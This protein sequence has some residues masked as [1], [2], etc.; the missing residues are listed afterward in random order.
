[1]L[2]LKAP[3]D[4]KNT[5][6]LHELFVGSFGTNKARR[7]IPN[8][9]YIYG[10]FECSYPIIDEETG[11]VISLCGNPNGPKV[12]YVAYEA[13][14]NATTMTDAIKTI[15]TGEFL[16]LFMQVFF[17]T[18]YG[19]INFDWTHGDLH[20]ENIMVRDISSTHKGEF[21]IKYPLGNKDFY[22]QSNSV[23]TFI[24]YGNSHI[25]FNGEHY[26]ST[27]CQ[28]SL[29]PTKSFPISDIYKFLL[30]VGYH[31]LQH[32]RKD[33]IGYIARIFF[34]FNP[35]E[36]VTYAIKEQRRAFYNIPNTPYVQKLFTM[37]SMLN[38]LLELDEINAIV[39]TSNDGGRQLLDCTL[40]CRTTEDAFL[41]TGTNPKARI[42]VKSL[43]DYYDLRKIVSPEIEKDL[44]KQIDDNLD[45]YT[46]DFM[47][48]Y[49]EELEYTMDIY[50]T[51]NTNV[52]YFEDIETLQ[53]DYIYSLDSLESFKMHIIKLSQLRAGISLLETM[54]R[55][56]TFIF[57]DLKLK[58]E[59]NEL[60]RGLDMVIKIK[61]GYGRIYRI[62]KDAASFME[63]KIRTPPGPS[64]LKKYP[65][66]GWY[67]TKSKIYL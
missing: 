38:Y 11:N 40:I 9:A 24:D 12:Q 67:L 46:K 36:D 52:I 61:S 19:Y 54:S 30:F 25:V 33:I 42:M 63:D 14:T 26:G 8:F 22:V 59:F 43:I 18:Y 50:N 48:G 60:N 58:R 7:D 53:D 15:T 56:G 28:G 13:I 62:F 41:I 65:E 4:P 47:K 23:A 44:R 64:K 27:F 5:E 45:K 51:L 20:G 6:L 2:V 10:G 29:Y 32:N 39:A 57:N 21:Y 3:Q 1:M 16:S 31:A 55:V 17:S 34:F 66:L 35:E 49:T 37:Q